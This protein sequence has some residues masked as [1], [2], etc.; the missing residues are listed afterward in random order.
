MSAVGRNGWVD[1]KVALV[2][3][4]ATGIGR[5]TVLALVQAG[6]HGVVVNYRANEQEASSVASQVVRL[7]GRAVTC[8]ADVSDDVDVR[9][10][11]GSA[12]REF[13]RLDILVNSAGW[14]WRVPLCDLD[15]VTDEMWQRTFST[16]V[17][18]AF[19]CSRAAAPHLRE[20]GDGVIVNIASVAGI[21]GRGS[22]IPYCVSKAGLVGLTKSLA[23]ALAP[24]IRVNAVA[25]GFV[26]T[27]WNEGREAWHPGIARDTLLG[28]VAQAEDVAK[29]VV[30]LAAAASFV[31][32]QVVICDGGTTL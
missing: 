22:S 26:A 1:G 15:A 8:R 11:V 27:R 3:G 20:R 21:S 28:R 7:G 31:T 25:P 17:V 23:I 4:G 30:G 19:N 32:G 12:V 16:N 29:V 10:M 18:G 24:A 9:S 6:A 5:A 2:T 14:T 13:G